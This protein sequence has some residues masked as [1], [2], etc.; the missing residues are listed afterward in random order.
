M[1]PA[2]FSEIRSAC[3]EVVKRSRYVTLNEDKLGAY[4]RS[5]PAETAPPTYDTVHHFAGSPE[6]TL[7]YIVTLDA[8][9]FGSGYFPH[10]QKRSGMSGYFT[11][12]S[13]LKDYFERRGPFSAQALYELGVEG[14]GD[15]FNQ[16]LR[17]PVR[18]E[19][20][21]LF[22]KA[23][24]DL[25]GY[26]LS[27]FNGNFTALVEAAEN[28]AER[29]AVLLAEMPYF[30]DVATYE[31]FDVPLYKRAQIT[32]SDLAL[33][34]RGKGYGHF[35]DLDRLTIFADNLVPHVLRVDGVLHFEEELVEHINAGELIAPG[36][37]EEVEIRAVALHAVERMVATLREEG[38]AIA[39]Q[40]LDV[41]LWNRGQNYLYKAWPRH[42][43][44]TVFY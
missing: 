24:N 19:L 33:A 41:R 29:L 40:N 23:L 6:D 7:A 37:P 42:R 14:C 32:A 5:L 13:S 34:F 15:L 8:V 43:T 11:V 25:G 10:L 17:D 1:I 30:Q 3:A 21:Q 12:A 36:S 28:R 20:M 38:Q 2:I 22:R 9:N 44:R 16:D 18:A 39:A 26:L 27:R 31:D 4:A 35:T